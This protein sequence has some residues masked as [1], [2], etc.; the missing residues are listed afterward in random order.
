MNLFQ[1]E[2]RRLG[3]D[4]DHI[5]GELDYGE[6]LNYPFE[7]NA[8]E[9]LQFAERSLEIG[10][11]QGL[12]DCLTNAKRAIDCQIDKLLACFGYEFKKYSIHQKIDLLNKL[13][14][15]VPRILRKVR[16]KRNFL[17][18]EYLCPTQE[19]T[20][21][22][23]DIATL[24]VYASNSSLEPFFL[25]YSIVEDNEKVTESVQKY[26]YFEFKKEEKR[27]EVFFG[28]GQKEWPKLDFTVKDE[29]YPYLLSISTRLA[30]TLPIVETI[31]CILKL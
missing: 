7:I 2:F 23:L 1:Q 18:H 3:I 6:P 8:I 19:E 22:A 29:L 14:V 10:N 13:G 17:E 20:E 27:L 5:Y 12:I 16:S 11:K 24:F 30:K 4:I 28:D 25:S 9:F 26:V 31:E 15:I 21:D